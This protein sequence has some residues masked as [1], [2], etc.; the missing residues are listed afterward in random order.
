MSVSSLQTIRGNTPGH[1]KRFAGCSR[2][3][4]A[5]TWP[6]DNEANVPGSEFLQSRRPEAEPYRCQGSI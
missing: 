4:R 6:S 5:K 1:E 2:S 3:S